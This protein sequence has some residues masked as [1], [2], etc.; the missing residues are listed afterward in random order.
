MNKGQLHILGYEQRVKV[1]SRLATIPECS[2]GCVDLT[3]DAVSGKVHAERSAAHEPPGLEA[4]HGKV[5]AKYEA[6]WPCAPA[7]ASLGDTCAGHRPGVSST[8]MAYSPEV[9][10]TCRTRVSEVSG[11]RGVGM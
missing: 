1:W 9:V 10:A 2:A 8:E 5:H 3:S 4:D 11:I 6:S 7:G